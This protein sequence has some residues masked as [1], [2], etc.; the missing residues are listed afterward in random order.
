MTQSPLN[1]RGAVDLSALAPAKHQERLKEQTTNEDGVQIIPGPL[2]RD[3]TVEALQEFLELSLHV[4][5]V[6]VFRSDRSQGSLELARTLTDLVRDLN[7]TIGLGIVDADNAPEIVQAFQIQALPTTVAVLGGNP[8]P[9]FQGTAAPEDASKALDSVLQAA[10][11][12][13]V[14][15][16]LD[17]DENGRLPEPELPPHVKEARAALDRGDLEAAHAAYTKA[18]KEN[19]GD[20][21]SKLALSQVE[22]FQR[23]TDRDPQEVLQA[24]ST[25]PLTDVDAHLLAADVEV[26]ARMPESAFARLLDVIRTV[27]GDERDR[28]RLRLIDLFGIVGIH[29]PVV[30][31]ARKQLASALM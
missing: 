16:R 1:I 10:Q 18:I 25:A 13:G 30:S 11:Q 3:V 15:G 4:P 14:L 6:I 27:S 22:L 26:M 5:L 28:A 23:I 2:V 19:P 9:L 24:A 20:D 7:G 17:G 8:V 29:D 31:E 12:L 21:E